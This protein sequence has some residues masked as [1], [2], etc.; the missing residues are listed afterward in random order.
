MTT[1]AAPP[2]G[3]I[4]YEQ[5]LRNRIAEPSAICGPPVHDTRTLWQHLPRLN[6]Y[7]VLERQARQ[8]EREAGS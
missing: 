2:A 3:A 1:Q 4:S 8:A 6:P 7:R 5:S